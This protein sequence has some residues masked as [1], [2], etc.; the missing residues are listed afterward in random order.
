M[1]F[2]DIKHRIKSCQVIQSPFMLPYP[3]T[4]MRF[5]LYDQSNILQLIT[6]RLPK[7]VV[8]LVT[9]VY[10]GV[11]FFPLCLVSSNDL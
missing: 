7:V 4:R 1:F 9:E 8:D 6:R 2:T 3:H 10:I 5:M 11:V